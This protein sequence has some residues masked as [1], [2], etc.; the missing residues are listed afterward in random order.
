[1]L[2]VFRIDGDSATTQIIDNDALRAALARDGQAGFFEQD[3]SVILT[4]D[5]RAMRAVLGKHPGTSGILEA[6]QAWRRS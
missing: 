5:D 3:G 2:I 1:M 4:G 6:G